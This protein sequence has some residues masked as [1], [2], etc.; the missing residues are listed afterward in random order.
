MSA[1]PTVNINN[2]NGDNNVFINSTFDATFTFS[3]AGS[4]N[5]Y[6]PF[7][8]VFLPP[9]LSFNSD[10]DIK[11]VGYYSYTDSVWYDSSNNVVESHP[12]SAIMPTTHV[13]NLKWYTVHIPYSSYNP[14]QPNL[15]IV[16]SVSVTESD[17]AVIGTPLTY[18]ATPHF[19]LGYDAL[20]NADDPV[21]TGTRQ[22]NFITPVIMT[23][24]KSNSA[25]ESEIATGPNFPFTYTLEIEFA[26][27]QTFTSFDITD[28]L[29]DTQVYVPNSIVLPNE[30]NLASVSSMTGSNQ[31][32]VPQYQ[33]DN[34]VI[35][36]FDATGITSS[37]S[38]KKLII[39]YDVYVP[40]Q[41]SN[42]N[43]ILNETTGASRNIDTTVQVDALYKSG[44][45]P[46]NIADSDSDTVTAK[47]VAIQKSNNS[48]NYAIPNDIITYTLNVQ[49]SDYFAF[50]NLTIDDILSDGQ[51]F[52]TSYVPNYTLETVTTTTNDTLAYTLTNLSNSRTNVNFDISSFRS[53][54]KGG[55]IDIGS[56][57]LSPDNNGKTTLTINYQTTINTEYNEPYAHPEIDIGDHVSNSVTITGLVHNYTTDI[58]YNNSQ[59]DD[60]NSTVNI[61]NI[62]LDKVVYA[63]N[64]STTLPERIF[65]GDS[66][67]YK[68]SLN[69]SHQNVQDLS[70]ID[71]LPPPIL[72]IDDFNTNII[73]GSVTP[74]TTS[75][76]I[77]YG[78][79]HDFEKAATVSVD[80]STN[81]VVFDFGTYQT[82]DIQAR[83]IE[84]YYTAVCNDAAVKDG[85]EMTN[86]AH[87]QV[88]NTMGNPIEKIDSVNVVIGEPIM[89]IYKNIVSV[90]SNI[91]R[92]NPTLNVDFGQ[93]NGAGFNGTINDT[94]IST[95]FQTAYNGKDLQGDDYVRYGIILHNRGSY[96]PFNVIVTD[97]L[98]TGVEYVANSINI[99]DGN[100]TSRGSTGD[101]FGSGL[102]IDDVITA[103]D[104]GTN[105]IVITYDVQIDKDALISDMTNI[106]NITNYASVAGTT[107]DYTANFVRGSLHDTSEIVAEKPSVVKVITSTSESHTTHTDSSTT[108][109]AIGETVS[110]EYTINMP[111]GKV[112]NFRLEDVLDDYYSISN[113]NFVL[114]SSVTS[115]TT[116][117]SDIY[118]DSIFSF[119]NVTNNGSSVETIVVSLD[120]KLKDVNTVTRSTTLNDN[121]KLRYVDSDGNRNIN[122]N[123]V[124]VTVVEPNVTIDKYVLYHPTSPTDYVEYRVEVTNNSGTNTSKAFNL[125]ITDVL[126]SQFTNVTLTSASPT[127]SSSTTYPNIIMTT[128]ELDVGETVYFTYRSNL[129]NVNL[130]ETV[131][132][133]AAVKSDSIASTGHREYNDSYLSKCFVGNPTIVKSLN[134][135]DTLY[136]IGETV[137]YALKLRLQQN[138]PSTLIVKDNIPNGMEMLSSTLSVVTS[139]TGPNGEDFNGSLDTPTYDSNNNEWTFSNVVINRDEDLDND[140][141]ELRYSMRVIN[142]SSNVNNTV[143]TNNAT[144]K[145]TNY[146]S[147]AV[148]VTSNDVDITVVEPVLDMIL[149]RTDSH[150]LDSTSPY[151][152]ELYDGQIVTY[153][154][155]IDHNVLSSNKAY[156]VKLTSTLPSN[157]TIVSYTSTK[158]INTDNSTDNTIDIKYNNIGTSKST[159]LKFNIR[160]DVNGEALRT[161]KILDFNLE[162]KSANNSHARDGDDGNYSNERTY[163]NDYSRN[164]DYTV[165]IVATSS[166]EYSGTIMVE[167]IIIKR[168]D[169]PLRH[170]DFDFND[171][172]GEYW[173]KEYKDDDNHLRSIAGSVTLLQQR[174]AY[175]HDL[176]L[177]LPNISNSTGRIGFQRYNGLV[178]EDVETISIDSLV[179]ERVELFQSVRAYLRREDEY[180]NDKPSSVRFTIGFDNLDAVINGIPPYYPHVNCYIARLSDGNPTHVVQYRDDVFIA[181]KDVPQV[182]VLPDK[183]DMWT[184]VEG[185]PLDEVLPYFRDWIDQGQDIN[186][187]W[188]LLDP[189]EGKYEPSLTD[190]SYEQYIGNE[191]KT[192]NYD[193]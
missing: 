69:L 167:D 96:R 145:F 3:N 127:L 154:L 160:Y 66:V 193:I 148:S 138:Q 152:D 44:V 47:S 128:S 142:Q 153:T 46:V 136:S 5:A 113:I 84:L 126:T 73:T 55:Y 169:I 164:N 64:G 24:K 61:G 15:D 6:A 18:Y 30:F 182:L 146:V 90:T 75:W 114:G 82:T 121:V 79:N 95:T 91:G 94:S 155:N 191:W 108:D 134:S 163:L 20:D 98:P 109:A 8:D 38:N 143:L 107:E 85:L 105:M 2:V 12:K 59:S 188:Y 171:V 123:S 159:E 70:I 122:G 180:I 133:T 26:K 147:S 48:G 80:S 40:Y 166:V 125:E 124:D 140:Y 42:S 92:V 104:D 19:E 86:Q 186:D 62:T 170:G 151:Y 185:I 76:S 135:N 52:N 89:S 27:D 57:N 157:M 9:G 21:I 88:T 165:M 173:I 54:L 4:V 187:Q 50:T 183:H 137:P 36:Y 33:G 156:Q 190:P 118:S 176:A 111:I 72:I 87:L 34:L 106:S 28:E 139:G 83:T 162:W 60:S 184:C 110:L 1:I 129:N 63:V 17:G 25:P 149:E 14:S 144:L 192:R 102:T 22:S 174:A 74:V 7:Y 43:L 172:V 99:T 175:D 97:T 101:I 168:S 115:D 177:I 37:G 10:S 141:V 68:L 31:I 189:V 181:K 78:P 67:T 161:N 71:Y 13:D 51:T 41:D 11:Y 116:I 150:V 77:A 179:D 103:V 112:N 158:G 178:K 56:S 53:L 58:T 23:V 119:G 130:G 93:P 65:P 49:I 132:N 39:K 16:K 45:N 117:N 100:G 81:C 120:A 32:K 131:D 29:T 35:N